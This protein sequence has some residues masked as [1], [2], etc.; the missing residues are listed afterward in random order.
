VGPRTD[1]E[2]DISIVSS[3]DSESNSERSIPVAMCTWRVSSCST[4]RTCVRS[5]LSSNNDFTRMCLRKLT[6]AFVVE[7]G[8]EDEEARQVGFARAEDQKTKSL[9]LSASSC[10]LVVSALCSERRVCRDDCS[11]LARH[12]YVA[13]SRCLIVACCCKASHAF[14]AWMACASC[15]LIMM[16]W[17]VL[18]FS[19]CFRLCNYDMLVLMSRRRLSMAA[20]WLWFSVLVVP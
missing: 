1:P 19:L 2:R 16:A 20:S 18:S 14:R 4:V 13:A 12:L 15:L 17:L 7:L 8:E 10:S 6:V 11:V 9:R 5:A 3:A